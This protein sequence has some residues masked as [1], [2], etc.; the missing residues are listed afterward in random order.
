MVFAQSYVT[1]F[2]AKWL[3][4]TARRAQLLGTPD[5]QSLADLS[6][7]ISVVRDMRIAPSSLRLIAGL[8]IAAVLPMLPLFLFE[9]PLAELAQ[10]VFGRLFGL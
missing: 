3:G 10:R 9:Y 5:L 7:S 4:D 1:D 8:A 6:N 2:D